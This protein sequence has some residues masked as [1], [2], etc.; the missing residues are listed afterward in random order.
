MQY[1]HKIFLFY[2]ENCNKVTY[3]YLFSYRIIDDL[4]NYI[5]K[6]IGDD[7]RKTIFNYSSSGGGG[8][9]EYDGD[10]GGGVYDGVVVRELIS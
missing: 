8:G 6:A 7:K 3:N 9:G 10:D 1:C 5:S 2:Y 4:Y